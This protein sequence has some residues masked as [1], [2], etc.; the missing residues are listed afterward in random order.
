M[1]QNEYFSQLQPD[2]IFLYGL[3]KYQEA[4]FVVKGNFNSETWLEEAASAKL[5]ATRVFNIY[6]YS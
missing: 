4:S 1:M 3:R 2:K 6:A 5:F